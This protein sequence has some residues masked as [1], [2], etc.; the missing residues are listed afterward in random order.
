VRALLDTHTFLWWN[1]DAPRLSRT[2]RDVLG[3]GENVFL[4]SVASIWEIAIKHARGRLDLPKPPSEYLPERMAHYGYEALRVDVSHALRA[5]RLPRHHN[6]PFDRLLIAQ[7]LVEH[8]PVVTSD[9]HFE[10][11]GVEVIW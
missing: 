10:R 6:D 7:A 5:G 11:Y 1:L 4:L 3:E 9:P 8:L 2:S